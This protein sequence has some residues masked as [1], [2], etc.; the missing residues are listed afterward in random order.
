MREVECQM[1]DGVDVGTSLPHSL[2]IVGGVGCRHRV[3]SEGAAGDMEAPLP[4][5]HIPRHLHGQRERIIY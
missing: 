4:P 5:H 3:K 1:V 2:A